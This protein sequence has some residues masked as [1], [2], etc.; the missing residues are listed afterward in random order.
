MRLKCFEDL[1][2]ETLV[3]VKEHEDSLLFT[4]ATGETYMLS[5]EQDCCE[6][7][8]IDDIAGDLDDLVGVVVRAE[9]N[10]SQACPKSEDDESFT[11]T[12]YRIQTA[13]GLVVV[14]WY[15]TSN[16]YYSESVKWSEVRN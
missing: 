11:W 5:H 10:S 4:L 8:T 3:S 13:R 2:G 9:E 12:F 6:S 14:R 16:G 1:K 7:V 15:G